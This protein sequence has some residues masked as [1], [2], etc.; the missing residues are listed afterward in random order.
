M[1]PNKFLLVLDRRPD[2]REDWY[3]KI[4]TLKNAAVFFFAQSNQS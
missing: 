3:K 2:R 4:E 1:G